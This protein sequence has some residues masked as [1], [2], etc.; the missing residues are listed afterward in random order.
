[1]VTFFAENFVQSTNVG[2]EITDRGPC[3]QIDP[4]VKRVFG[5]SRK[6]LDRQLEVLLFR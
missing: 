5:V 2:G 4:N 3:E 1:M 6:G